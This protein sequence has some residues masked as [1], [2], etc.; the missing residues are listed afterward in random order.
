M[1]TDLVALSHT[2]YELDAEAAADMC[3]SDG[4]GTN[5]WYWWSTKEAYCPMACGHCYYGNEAAE[6]A[7]D[8]KTD[9]VALSRTYYELDAEAAA[10]MCCSDGCGTNGWYWW[11]TKEAYC[12]MACG[13]CYYGSAIEAAEKA[14]DEKTDLVAEVGEEPSETKSDLS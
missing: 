12:P 5:G 14:S 7:K 3:C 6:T 2:Y 9:L 11:S 10:D 13:Y 4:C 1:G 8:E